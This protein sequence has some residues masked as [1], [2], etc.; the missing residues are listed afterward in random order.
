[1]STSYAELV[2]EHYDSI[3]KL[4]RQYEDQRPV[5]LFDLQKAELFAYPYEG[6]LSQLKMRSKISLHKQYQRAV[7][8]N[9]I[10]VFVKDSEN[11]NIVSF[12][13]EIEDAA[14]A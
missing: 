7:E 1:M 3:L 14:D 13:L 6:L 4:Y 2:K 12:S 10:V 8:N 11:N 5:I 9:Y